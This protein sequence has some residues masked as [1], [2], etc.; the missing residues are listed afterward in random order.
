MI[1]S[2]K[3]GTSGGEVKKIIDYNFNVVAKYL[4]KDVRAL[5][6]EERK[7]LSSDYLSEKSLV[8]D[9]DEEQW[10][11]YSEGSWVKI[12][13]GGDAVAY[14]KHISV[15]D[16]I[17]N[18]MSILFDQHGVE[19]PVVQLYMMNDDS[20]IPVIGGVKKIDSKHNIT[21]STDLPFDGKVVIK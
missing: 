21:L 17:N 3:N 13:S 11:K 1:K 6:T 9:T 10:Y 20:F 2:W 18:G 5:S 15:S 16:W 4:S 19:N 7:A 12:P 8:Y 14:T